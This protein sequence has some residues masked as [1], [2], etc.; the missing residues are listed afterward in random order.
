MSIGRMPCCTVI[1]MAR[2]T[3]EILIDD[4]TGEEI[5]PDDHRRVKLAYKGR[6]H[7]LDL[8]TE[9]A[10]ALDAALAPFIGKSAAAPKRASKGDKAAI[11]AWA[12]R[13][14]HTLGDRGRIPAEIE[15]AYDAH[16]RL[17]S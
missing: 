11:R 14:G 12:R 7:Q 8:S 3:I 9:S 1:R 6:D 2:K 16:Q 13:Q 4:Y 10:A 17:V 15:S 5:A